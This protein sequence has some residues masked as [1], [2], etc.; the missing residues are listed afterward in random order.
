M[1]SVF[2]FLGIFNNANGF[3]ALI[4]IVESM[5]DPTQSDTLSRVILQFLTRFAFAEETIDVELVECLLSLI[6][7]YAISLVSEGYDISDVAKVQIA[8]HLVRLMQDI[9]VGPAVLEM[10]NKELSHCEIVSPYMQGNCFLH[11]YL[12]L[13]MNCHVCFWS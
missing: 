13:M 12:S 11:D 2:C 4:M 9:T 5:V 3:K 7:P 6:N 1:K 10:V 8:W